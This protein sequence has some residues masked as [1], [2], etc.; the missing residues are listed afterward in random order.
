MK[1]L[2]AL[3]FDDSTSSLPDLDFS[4]DLPELFPDKPKYSYVQGT[5]PSFIEKIKNKV[6]DMFAPS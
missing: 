6:S 3:N 1:N 4:Q 5:E 2:P